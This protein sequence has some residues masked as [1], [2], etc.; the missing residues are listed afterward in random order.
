MSIFILCGYLSLAL[1]F[2]ALA[3]A[4]LV[5]VVGSYGEKQALISNQEQTDLQAINL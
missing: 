2:L 4:S 5:D 1:Q 3:Y